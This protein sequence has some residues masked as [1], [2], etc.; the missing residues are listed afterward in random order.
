M[1][2]LITILA[3]IFTSVMAFST[4]WSNVEW[5]GN[6]VGEGYS[7]KYKAVV[8][9]EFSAPGFINNLQLKS[10]IPVLHVC[11]PSAEFGAFSLDA[12]QYEI[13]GAGA[14]FHLAVFTQKETIFTAECGNT[15]YTF[16]VFYVDGEESTPDGFITPRPQSQAQKVI[17]NGQVVILKNGLR[18]NLLGVE[19]K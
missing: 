3:L 4:D 17:E 18:Y 11:F 12:S 10:N 13:E 16:T 1:R 14:F 7:E 8:E 19:I 2:K 6:G 9:P 15:T 5:L